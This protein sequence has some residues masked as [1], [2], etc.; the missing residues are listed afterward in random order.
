M[1][2][3]KTLGL[4]ETITL[5]SKENEKKEILAKVDTGASMSS[6]DVNLADELGINE[7]IGTKKVKSASGINVRPFIKIDLEI[8]GIKIEANMTLANR[9][10]M[11]Y[12]VLIGSDVMKEYNF[13]VNPKQKIEQMP[14][15]HNLGTSY[16]AALM[17]LGSLSSLWTAEEMSKYFKEVDNL[18]IRFVEIKLDPKKPEILYKGEP[19]KDYDCVYVK[20]SFRF[21]Q[22]LE[23]ITRSLYHSTYMP[24][25]PESFSIV[26]DKLSTHL[27][28]Q[29]SKIPMPTTYFASS[30]NAAEKILK[31]INY[32][33]ILKL[34]KG[35][36]GKGVLFAD[37]YITAKTILDALVTLNQPFIIQEFIESNGED[38]RIIVAG[39]RVV[40]S[41]K[42]KSQTGEIRSNIHA[43]GIGMKFTPTSAMRSIAIRTAKLLRAEIC[44][45]DIL[46]SSK[47]PLVIEANI[48]PGLQGITKATNINV[49]HELAKYLFERTKYI[50]EQKKNRDTSKIFE[51][52]GIQHVEEQERK[53]NIISNLE[54]RGERI[55][56]PSLA[57]KISE[58]MEG[59]DIVISTKKGKIEISKQ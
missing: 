13:K 16:K 22:V 47:G 5:F 39:D 19:I 33:I 57:S 40:A 54:M 3:Y 25:H 34:P 29:E 36:Q 48:S 21:A 7:I 17:S 32:P 27:L 37:S 14:T 41:M 46:E 49:A 38:T 18:D 6:I 53:I 42:R 45:I 2:E 11:K 43:G 23:A 44:G 10:H 50:K 4:I 55:I 30:S 28:L 24:I 35:T 8:R 51:D 59:E 9:E 52:I 1:E 58:F 26:H 20:G 12:P 56:L 31:R 15:N